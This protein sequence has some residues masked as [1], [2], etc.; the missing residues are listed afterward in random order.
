MTILRLGV[1]VQISG[2]TINFSFASLLQPILRAADSEVG[3]AR[4]LSKSTIT[5]QLMLGL[6]A[7][8]ALANLPGIC[9]FLMRS[10]PEE[11]Q[12]RLAEDVKSLQ[13][14]KDLS[15]DSKLISLGALLLDTVGEGVLKSAVDFFRK[16]QARLGASGRIDP[17]ADASPV[18]VPPVVAEP[19]ITPKAG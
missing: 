16:S 4:A 11:E 9:L 8:E 10:I 15:D 7:D 3:R 2:E 6:K 17:P 18:I 13:Q 19:A 14:Q 1:S 12:K 5:Q